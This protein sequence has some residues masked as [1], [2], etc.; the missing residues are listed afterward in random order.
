MT[1]THLTEVRLFTA[2]DGEVIDDGTVVVEDRT[3]TWA[4]PTMDAPRPSGDDVAVDGGGRFVMPGMVEG[5]C[6]IAYANRGP[7]ELDATTPALAMLDAVENAQTLLAAGFTTAISFGSAHGI[8]VPLRDAIAG[9]RIPG[10]RLVASGPDIGATA[11]N[12]DGG[13]GLNHI[14]D[15]PWAVRAAVRELARQRCDVIKIFLDGEHLNTVAPP[16][17]LTWTDEEVDAAVGEAHGRGMRVAC[18]AR[19]AAAVK[20]AVRAGVDFIGHANY[21]DDEAVELLRRERHRLSVGPGIAWEVSLLERGHEIGLPRDAMERIGYRAEIDATV[22]AVKRLRDAGVPLLIGG[23]YGL[24][25]APHG[26]NA[27]DLQLF[28]ELFSMSPVEALL[29]ATRDGGSAARPEGDLGT[30]EEGKL[31]D[32]L[33][34]DGDPTTDVAL[35]QDPDRIV[36]VMQGGRIWQGL[37]DRRPWRRDRFELGPTGEAS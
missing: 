19:S 16:G 21:L 6:H 4:G 5:H 1:R 8:D 32:L 30:L 29:C 17:V 22:D 14:A 27:R 10:P 25:I 24:N 35:L 20:Q 7:R 15:G 31:A 13:P 12:A 23:D 36:A 33:V 3:I 26:T 9:G 28:V 18:H 37:A 34:V 2:V 11:S